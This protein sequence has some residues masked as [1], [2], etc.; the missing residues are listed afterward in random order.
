[1]KNRFFSTLAGFAV[2]AAFGTSFAPSAEA[3]SLEMRHHKGVACETCHVPGAEHPSA[4]LTQK[5]TEC[6][7]SMSS[8]T[9]KT[10]MVRN[11]HKSPHY[12]DLLDCAEC[13]QEH[14]PAKN[15]CADC[16]K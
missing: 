4:S 8:I 7:G 6:H 10:P 3:A 12:D 1:M 2:L 11:P 5:C 14:A 13:H 9:I 16:H 15:L